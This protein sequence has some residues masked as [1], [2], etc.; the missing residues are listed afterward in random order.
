M[1]A[2]QTQVPAT[3]CAA[4]IDEAALATLPELFLRSVKAYAARPALESFGKKLTYAQMGA[5]AEAIA[6]WLQDQGFQK[7]DR[8]AI[9]MPNVMAYPPV[10]FG[11]L[12]GG[13]TVVNVNPLYTP[14]ELTHQ[15]DDAG[16]RAIFVLE[17]FAH[18]VEA[19]SKSLKLDRIVMVSAGDFLGLKGKIVNLVARR[20]KKVVPAFAIPGIVRLKTVLAKGR[21]K[22]LQPV[23]LSPDDI[24][25]LQYTG[26]TT[27]V[28]KGAMLRHS[29]VAANVAQEAALLGNALAGLTQPIMVTALPLYHIYALT[30]F[31]HAT[32]L[33]GFQILIANPRDIAALIAT[34]K[35]TKFNLIPLVN[36]LFAA[37]INHPKIR[38][39]DFSGMRVSSAG[40][41][42][43]QAVVARK[44]K[45][46][47]GKAIIEGYGLSETSPILTA[48]RIDIE[49]FTGTI[50]FP[51]AS[52]QISLRGP[53]G[54]EVPPGEPGEICAK[55]PQVMAGYWNRPDETD[56][57][58]TEDGFFRTGDIGALQPDG[59]IKLIDRMKDMI[60]VS[61]FNVYPNEVEDVLAAHPKILEAAVVGI[62]DAH[63]GEAVRAFIVP[64]D[65][66]LTA[67]EVSAYCRENL[68]GYKLPR[69][70]E[71]RE[72]LPKSN[73][74]KILRRELRES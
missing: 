49:E 16:A 59:S 28:S 34:I 14:R 55:G 54:K 7:G 74:G 51:V 62:K 70:I 72:S 35:D 19:S 58:M 56:R 17:N 18:T 23:K 11:I 21:A 52:T 10:L 12:M 40:G 50:G 15:L 20:V 39:V 43:V 24:A 5:A 44:W 27:G 37:L 42:A 45:A 61:G 8:I 29:N 9:M 30:L 22:P 25:F 57:V 46:L 68:T 65:T 63:S 2:V 66:S 31:I 64:S 32:T 26:G 69:H 4:R 73:V 33:G 53:D 47:T 71:F 38:E 41:M 3:I 36:T 13:F 6:S 1:A 60:L 48:N 67:A